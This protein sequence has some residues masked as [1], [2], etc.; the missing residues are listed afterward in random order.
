MSTED[1]RELRPTDEQRKHLSMFEQWALTLVA[2]E[3]AEAAGREV[4]AL[5]L[6]EAYDDYITALRRRFH[7]GENDTGRP[8]V[9]PR[10][11]VRYVG[12]Q[13]A[14]KL[15]RRGE[16]VR[17]SGWTVAGHARYSWYPRRSA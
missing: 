4:F 17:F 12:P 13:R 10:I 7:A 11:G 1:A 9:H 6:E 2:M 5:E 14:R 15:R 16:D 3:K 8:F